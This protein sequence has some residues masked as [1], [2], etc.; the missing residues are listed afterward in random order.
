MD[1]PGWSSDRKRSPRQGDGHGTPASQ[2]GS[3]GPRSL[4]RPNLAKILVAAGSGT[5]PKE[6]ALSD[7][8]DSGGMLTMSGKAPSVCDWAAGSQNTQQPDATPFFHHGFHLHPADNA[9]ATQDMKNFIP[10]DSKVLIIYA[11]G[12]VGGKPNPERGA[13]YPCKGYLAELFRRNSKIHDLDYPSDDLQAS[14]VTPVSYYGKRVHYDVREFDPLMDSASM[15]MNDWVRLSQTV[16]ENYEHYD[17]FVVIHGADTMPY[18]ASALSFMLEHIGKTVILTGG[19]V[20]LCEPRTDALNN[21]I[22]AI[23]IAGHFFIPE[24]CLYCHGKLMRG[25]RAVHRSATDFDMYYSPIAPLLGRVGVSIEIFWRNIRQPNT[26]SPLRTHVNMCTQ[27]AVLHLFPGIS[28]SAIKALVSPPIKGVV[29]RSYGSGSAPIVRRDVL[30]VLRAATQSGVT[31]I[32]TSQ[33]REGVVFT[34]PR[35]HTNALNSVGVVPGGDM[36]CECALVKLSYLLGMFGD[37]TQKIRAYLER[38]LRGEI[39]VPVATKFTAEP[40]GILTKLSQA[41]EV[42]SEGQG[43]ELR[44]YL[45]GMVMCNAAQN[46]DVETM[47]MLVESSA[48][49]QVDV[50]DYDARTPLHIAAA[51]GHAGVAGYLITKGARVHHKDRSGHTPLVVAI[52][53]Q[54]EEVAKVIAQAGGTLGMPPD[55]VTQLLHS[56]IVNKERGQVELLVQFGASLTATDHNRM[57]P[58]TVA[59][60]QGSVDLVKRFLDTG[61][62]DLQSRDWW[63]YTPLELA[64]E[65]AHRT[66]PPQCYV[67]E[68]IADLLLQHMPHSEVHSVPNHDLVT[69]DDEMTGDTIET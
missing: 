45:N 1:G 6:P 40:D 69:G 28:S 21:I 33:A 4:S 18:T 14:L 46:G 17:G 61:C 3:D 31:I 63:G 22:D 39:T 5:Q 41:L 12:G 15:D 56:A 13:Y 23:T 64:R 27:V 53:N 68:A 60:Q 55:R 30:G 16:S 42:N 67:Y 37:D 29:L 25:A 8:T 62:C 9:T 57:T 65:A 43:E 32:N 26:L 50:Q 11:S 24:V 58:L 59:V 66:V 49:W 47:K 34:N 2:G 54:K 36:T 20:P 19:L 52:M 48:G 38:D 44:D 51:H 35:E 10:G 7:L